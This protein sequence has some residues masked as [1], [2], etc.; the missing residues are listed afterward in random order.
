M[1][2]ILNRLVFVLFY[3]LFFFSFL[4]RGE[5]RRV[6]SQFYTH[7][8]GDG[9]SVSKQRCQIGSGIFHSRL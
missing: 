5:G 2:L 6:R 8:F 7:E 3:F 4:S 9:Y 1:I